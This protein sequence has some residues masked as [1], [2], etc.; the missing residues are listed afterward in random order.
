MRLPIRHTRSGLIDLSIGILVLSL[1]L[2]L[3]Y[4]LL[5]TPVFGDDAF[6]HLSWS[7]DFVRLREM[8]VE[9]PKW[10]PFTFG[11]L[12]S[13]TFYFY[14]PFCYLIGD[15][16]YGLGLPLDGTRLYH[17]IQSLAL[18]LCVP[19]SFLYLR[20]I[21]PSDKLALAGSLL[22]S[23]A[24]YRYVD[25]YTRSALGEF[26]AFCWVPL[27]FLAVDLLVERRSTLRAVQ[28]IVLF[29]ISLGLLLLTNIPTASATLTVLIPYA[30]YRFG[31]KRL[32]EAWPLVVG[33]LLGALLC[34][35][36]LLPL[37]E[38]KPFIQTEKLWNFDVFGSDWHHV[39]LEIFVEGPRKNA[40]H[41][42]ALVSMAM[43]GFGLWMLWRGNRSREAKGWLLVG[44]L[45]IFLQLP[46]IADP[47]W[48]ILPNLQLLQFSWRLTIIVAL[49]LAVA[50]ILC[51]SEQGRAASL[52]LLSASIVTLYFYARYGYIMATYPPP[53]V[54]VG[55]IR[56]GA[57][58]YVNVHTMRSKDSV[59]AMTKRRFHDP[60]VQVLDG[61]ATITSMSGVSTA[62]IMQFS[63]NAKDS[64]TLQLHHFYWP[65]LTLESARGSMPIYPDQDGLIRARIPG[66]VTQWRLTQSKS[67]AERRGEL[68]SLVSVALFCSICTFGLALQ[69]RGHRKTSG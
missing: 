19:C 54:M 55:E 30:A 28:V 42:S 38:F 41:V 6:V 68:V 13:P 3:L 35:F 1:G 61:E 66:D 23:V 39:L 17:G 12:G 46:F 65:Q 57:P 18:L 37:I 48:S 50:I 47:L 27:C 5:N 67:Q 69:A 44:G 51:Y 45:A 22:Y 59:L 53:P 15:A 21:S 9:L 26:V 52:L 25:A 31:L 64:V 7:E 62:S 20:R 8:G 14:P 34:S 32:L 36:Y 60:L 33:S 24:A 10:T 11:G 43:L 63:I 4:A 58:E 29:A 16:L 40:I 56:Q 49:S 2:H